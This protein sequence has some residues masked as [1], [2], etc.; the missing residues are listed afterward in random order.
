MFIAFG[1]IQNNWNIGV[2]D[3][4]NCMTLGLQVIQNGYIFGLSG[5]R[6]C[7]LIDRPIEV[8]HRR[9]SIANG[10]SDS[11]TSG[12]GIDAI[13]VFDVLADHRF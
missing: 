8:G 5:A 13:F 4:S 7:R 2:V 6:K 1:T 12:L 3:I 10:T 11:D 9:F